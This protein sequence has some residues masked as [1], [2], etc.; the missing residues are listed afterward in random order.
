M[1]Q[2]EASAGT[3][4]GVPGR[5][6]VPRDIPP[7]LSSFSRER[8][9]LE[10][11]TGPEHARPL[12]RAREHRRPAPRWEP[13]PSASPPA[14]LRDVAKLTS[15]SDQD[16]TLT[17]PRPGEGKR[18]PHQPSEPSIPP[19]RPC[20]AAPLMNLVPQPPHP[21]KN[22]HGNPAQSLNYIKDWDH[23]GWALNR[24]PHTFINSTCT[25]AVSAVKT[26][27]LG[28]L[29]PTYLQRPL[30]REASGAKKSQQGPRHQSQTQS[31][32]RGSVSGHPTKALQMSTK[33]RNV[34]GYDTAHRRLCS[35]RGTPFFWKVP[36]DE[37]SLTSVI[38]SKSQGS[39]QLQTCCPLT[40]PTPHCVPKDWRVTLPRKPAPYVGMATACGLCQFA[41]A[42][43]SAVTKTKAEPRLSEGTQQKM[44]RNCT[45]RKEKL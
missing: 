20:Q 18:E 45:L 13:R 9:F 28:K 15:I 38:P 21:S 12:W 25:E 8:S 30:A 41:A 32:R 36:W 44:P 22:D 31:A 3:L 2:R 37:A 23:T 26:S 10:P 34:F 29:R 14:S 35:V 33:E 7:L 5:A 6:W 16:W 39:E 24:R 11:E 19:R 1:W 43:D 17:A 40:K 4:R 42:L 27:C